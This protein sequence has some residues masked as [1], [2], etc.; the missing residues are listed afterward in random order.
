MGQGT[1]KLSGLKITQNTGRDQK[2]EKSILIAEEDIFI[3]QV[4]RDHKTNKQY[5]PL[6]TSLLPLAE[7]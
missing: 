4:I 1:R 5:Y 7:M 3:A 2:Q 6:R